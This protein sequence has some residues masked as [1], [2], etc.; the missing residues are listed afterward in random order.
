MSTVTGAWS[1]DERIPAGVRPLLQ[2]YLD[3]VQ[4]ET[5]GL[6]AGFYVFGSIANGTYAEGVSDVDGLAL[7]SRQ[8]KP[9]ELA[10]LRDIHRD[11]ASRWP[12]PLFDVSYV[13]WSDRGRLGSDSPPHPYHHRNAFHDSGVFDFNSPRW[14]ATTWWQVRNGGIALLGPPPGDLDIDVSRETIVAESRRL[15]DTFW[16]DWT[17]RRA[18]LSGLRHTSHVDW[19]VLGM[20]RTWYTLREGDVTSK[21][22]AAA[23]ALAHLPARWHG[24]IRETLELR[25]RPR[26]LGVIDRAR[27]GIKAALFARHMVREIRREFPRAGARDVT[28]ADSRLSV[29]SDQ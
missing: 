19:V 3:A 10:R 4:A 20:L 18:Q 27:R 6:L 16:I 23:Y 25:Q 17:R 12:R 26:P 22:G 24:L 13:Q 11:I 2:H 1:G 9:R 28:P 15:V 14:S 29:R 21:E 8:C 5:P 7:L